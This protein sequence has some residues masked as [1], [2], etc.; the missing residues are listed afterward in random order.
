[1]LNELGGVYNVGTH[2]D[3]YEVDKSKNSADTAKAGADYLHNALLAFA[4][5]KVV[6]AKSAKEEADESH[7]DLILTVKVLIVGFL[8]VL[9]SNAA[10]K[11]NGCI[12]VN[13]VSAVLAEGITGVLF[14]A[15]LQA[16]SLI[17][18]HLGA[19]VLTVHKNTSKY[20]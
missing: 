8:F 20:F 19:T 10:V 3:L 4:H 5:H 11:A 6:N 13:R 14:N 17:I 7:N 2:K 15:A 18:I 12:S 9:D 16:D 1:M